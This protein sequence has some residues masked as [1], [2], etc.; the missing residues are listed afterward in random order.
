MDGQLFDETTRSLTHLASRRTI[1]RTILAGLGAAALARLG[2]A[3]VAAG[4]CKK[5][6]ATCD[7]KTDRCCGGARCKGKRC[8]CPAGRK[9][10]QNQCIPNDKCCPACRPGLKCCN[11]RCRAT[12]TDNGNC[13][14]CGNECFLSGSRFCAC[15]M[16]VFCPLGATLSQATC[17]CDCPAEQT[18]CGGVCRASCS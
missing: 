13:G 15:G 5:L 7:R 12:Q 14:T 16:C 10:C 6:G 17:S 3:P 11:G 9:P 18:N 4:T 2:T 8:T 1:A